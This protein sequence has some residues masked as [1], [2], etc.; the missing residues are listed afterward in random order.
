MLQILPPF[1]RCGANVIKR[2]ADNEMV[3]MCLHDPLELDREPI[4][5]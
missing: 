2:Y 5:I 3:D 4:E 1:H